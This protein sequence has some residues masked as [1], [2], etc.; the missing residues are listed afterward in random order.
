M[1]LGIMECHLT[2]G[3]P[4]AE[5]SPNVQLGQTKPA[6]PALSSTARDNVPVLPR[7]TVPVL[8]GADQ[9]HCPGQ[10]GYIVPGIVLAK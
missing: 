9:V 8:L 7:D 2:S 10:T 3:P 4:A 6:T 5:I 1:S